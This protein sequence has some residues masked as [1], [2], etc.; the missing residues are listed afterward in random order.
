MIANFGYIDGS[1]EY[2]ITVDTDKCS[3]CEIKPCIEACP[4][5]IFEKAED[6]YGNVILIVKEMAKR[7]LKEE[8]A[9]CKPNI[10]RMPLPCV[11][12]CPFDSI[13][14]SW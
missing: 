5:N 7:S 10:N 4:K 2:F 8:C 14:H 6:D 12:V 1:G 9:I 11:I 3:I 13:K